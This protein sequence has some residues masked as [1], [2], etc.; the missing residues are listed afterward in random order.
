MRG[1]LRLLVL[2]TALTA[3][4]ATDDAHAKRRAKVVWTSVEIHGRDD[5]AL[6][7]RV[8]KLLEKEGRRADWGKGREAPVEATVEVREL[9]SVVD[10]D[11]VRV[12]CTAV[13][14]VKG[15]GAAKSK[16]SYGGKPS[17]R[18]KLEKH[19][20]ELVSRGI[21]TRLADMARSQQGGWKVGSSPLSALAR[22]RAEAR[23]RPC[24]WS[25]VSCA[26][27][28]RAPVSWRTQRDCRA[29]SQ[30][31]SS[32]RVESGRVPPCRARGPG[33]PA[34]GNTCRSSLHRP[35][36]KPSP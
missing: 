31:Y 14:K 11:V 35:R 10:G 19:V 33:L 30:R 18:A 3:I 6:Q 22:R 7:A 32:A 27:P 23:N 28:R 9:V 24:R 34:C 16:F 36:A 8:K 12:T 15:I 26:R 17:D 20:L 25:C 1:I 13:G 29:A 21:V 4:T 5:A 2:A